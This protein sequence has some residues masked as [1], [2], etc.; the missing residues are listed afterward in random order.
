MDN[1]IFYDGTY[2]DKANKV[3][4]N[5]L[6]V[7]SSKA[8]SVAGFGEFDW[9]GGTAAPTDEKVLFMGKEAN[10]N[11][12]PNAD[13]SFSLTKTQEEVDTNDSMTYAFNPEEIGL[14]PGS[15][16]T[17]Y[18]EVPDFEAGADYQW[19]PYFRI[20]NTP[21]QVPAVDEAGNPVYKKDKDGNDV[22]DAEGNKVQ[23]VMDST[24]N[25]GSGWCSLD[26][27]NI[28]DCD[29]PSALNESYNIYQIKY[30]DIVAL[31]K[32]LCESNEKSAK[33]KA[34]KA[35]TESTYVMPNFDTDPWTKYA[36]FMG[37]ADRGMKINILAVTVGKASN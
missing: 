29:P 26:A 9:S 37:V 6:K 2:D 24:E 28:I 5:A 11:W 7:D 30:D 27:N 33:K 3:D 35:G 32:S 17:V 4:G 10:S 14:V 34:D 22:L 19:Y 20:Q 16:L 18:Y 25:D 23:D 21:E 13:N 1:V 15:V 12:W 31:H 36:D 8:F